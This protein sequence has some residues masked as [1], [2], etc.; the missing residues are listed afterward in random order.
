MHGRFPLREMNMN[1]TD[2]DVIALIKKT[3][4][5]R[6]LYI[7]WESEGTGE[8][9]YYKIDKITYHLEQP[10]G[11]HVWHVVINGQTRQLRYSGKSWQIG[12]NGY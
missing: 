2:V 7:V 9:T 1:T 6:P 12:S 8:K 3:G 5:I 10:A 11:H 4:K